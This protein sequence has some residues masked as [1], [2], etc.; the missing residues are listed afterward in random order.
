ME[1]EEEENKENKENRALEAPRKQEP[2]Q[3][4]ARTLLI[5]PMNLMP[6]FQPDPM[7]PPTMMMYLQTLHELRETRWKAKERKEWLWQLLLQ[8]NGEQATLLS[9]LLQD[10]P[11]QLTSP[12]LPEGPSPGHH[13]SHQGV[14]AVN[15]KE[16][17][18][19]GKSL[20]HSTW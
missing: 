4:T 17:R 10:S 14:V 19:Q 7:M 20:R 1:E 6:H 15:S 11:L 12:Q 18:N 5:A 13:P 8:R 2:S 9:W 3:E 16:K